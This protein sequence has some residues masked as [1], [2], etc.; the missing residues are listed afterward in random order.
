MKKVFFGLVVVVL[1]VVVVT[2]L[3]VFQNAQAEQFSLENGK[4]YSKSKTLG[5]KVLLLENVS[6]IFD[7]K[8]GYVL[9]GTDWQGDLPESERVGGSDL[10]LMNASGVAPKQLV[11][12]FDVRNALLC[13]Q[14]EQVLYLTRSMDLWSVDFSGASEQKKLSKIISPSLSADEKFLVYQKLNN[15]WQMGQYFENAQGIGLYDFQKAKSKMITREPQDFNPFFTLRKQKILFHSVNEFGIASLFVIDVS[16]R[17]Q[18]QLTNLKQKFVSD[19]TIPIASEKPIWQS[20]YELLFES[21]R[22]IWKLKFNKDYTKV[23][24]ARR[25]GYGLLN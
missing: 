9:Y 20:D 3:M 13:A 5:R 24:D 2:F 10:W 16:G 4:L 17:N 15:D 11:A 8:A 22:E 6:I 18:E 1:C 7:Q 23:L 25:V 12:N 21:D 19:K 14:D